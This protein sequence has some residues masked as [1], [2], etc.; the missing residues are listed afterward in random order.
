[1]AKPEW[2]VD[3]S[4]TVDRDYLLGTQD[5]ELARLGVQHR[6][7]RPTVLN[8]WKRAGITV[9]SRVIDV[10]AGPGFATVDL[11][12]IVG[13]GGA[14]GAVERSAKFVEAAAAACR[15]R[16]LTNGRFPELALVA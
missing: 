6:V 7:W 16:R 15:Q 8:C 12:Q 5:Q 14:G 11:A 13:P 1:Q 3:V 9:G 2:R 4:S 10:G